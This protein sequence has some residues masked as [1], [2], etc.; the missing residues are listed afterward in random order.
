MMYKKLILIAFIFIACIDFDIDAPYD[1]ING[2]YLEH[3]RSYDF[4]GRRIAVEN[5]RGY[6]RGSGNNAD[7]IVLYD[8]AD[9]Y[10]I[11]TIN[12]YQSDHPKSDFTIADG[13]AYVVSDFFGLEIVDFNQTSP[14][15]VGFLPISGVTNSI[16]LSNDHA[17]VSGNTRLVDIDVSDIANP[18]HIAEYVF[19]DSIINADV[20]SDTLYILMQ[21]GILQIIDI[22]T[23]TS[24]QLIAEHNLSDSLSD[25]DYFVK[26]NRYLYVTRGFDIDAYEIM[27]N[28]DLESR[29]TLSFSHGIHFLRMYGDFGLALYDGFLFNRLYLLNLTYPSRPCIG[30]FYE[31]LENPDYATLDGQYIYILS[32]LLAVFE[33]KEIDQ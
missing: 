25:A 29:S 9:V 19:N 8:F 11:D 3:A 20:V 14:Q 21:G 28:G 7:C 1:D 31:L 33:I 12:V 5:E 24:P 17:F 22:A 32:P 15:L 18:I 13:Y 26:Y 27:D 6:I 10:R 30:E 2:I 4:G 16:I 23:P